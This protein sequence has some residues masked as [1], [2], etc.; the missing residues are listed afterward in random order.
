M[1]DFFHGFEHVVHC[2]LLPACM[3]YGAYFLAA[4]PLGETTAFDPPSLGDFR[5]VE[6]VYHTREK[7]GSCMRKEH[8]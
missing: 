2:F 3:F 6:K 1:P 7:E 4:G 5:S 8:Q